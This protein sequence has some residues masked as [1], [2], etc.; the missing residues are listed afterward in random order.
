MNH[1]TFILIATFLGP[2]AASAAVGA[3]CSPKAVA[4]NKAIARTVFEEILSKGRIAENESIYHPRFVAHGPNRDAGREEDRA[5]SEG[6]RQ[7]APDLRMDVLRIVAECDMV[8]VHW[9]GSGTNT[10]TGNGL[11]ATGKRMSNLWGMTIF[12][13]EDGKI[14]EEWTSFDQYPMLKQLGLLGGDASPEEG[15]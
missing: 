12:R 13:M 3:D 4:H 1:L 9:S 5:A 14:A 2:P 11:P 7:A 6:W 15:K 10:G 8:A